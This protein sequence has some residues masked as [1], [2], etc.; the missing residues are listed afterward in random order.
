[1]RVLGIDPGTNVCGWG[2]VEATRPRSTHLGHGVIRMKGELPGRL[3]K[4]CAEIDAVIGKWSPDVVAVEGVFTH[5]NARSALIL[6]HSRG[7]S[8]LCAARA[9]LSVEEYT[10]ATVKKCVV[11]NGRAEK[12]QVQTM[13]AA[14]LGIP[15]P[16]VTDAAD[17]LA[18]ALCHVQNASVAA[19]LQ[20]GLRRSR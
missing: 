16:K 10:P 3:A 6:G 12:R 14:L 19:R 1:M 2:V 11:G 9:G 18:V 13:V 7:V 17:A 8:L 20:N 15:Q 4:L 5:R